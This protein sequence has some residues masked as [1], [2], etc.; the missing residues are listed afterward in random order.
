MGSDRRRL[1]IGLSLAA[2]LVLGAWADRKSGW[3]APAFDAIAHQFYEIPVLAAIRRP[4]QVPL[5]RIHLGTLV[6]IVASGLIA[7]PW[8]PRHAR[9]FWAIIAAGY[10]IR[11]TIWI[12]GGN[13]PLVPGDSC[14]YLEVASSVYRGEG[15]VKHY[16]E[17][18]FIDYPAI[19]QNR[20]VLDDWATP[21]HAYVLAGAYRLTGVVPGQSIESTVAVAKGTNFLL[22]MLTLP[23]IYGFAR[24]RFG[25]GVALGSMALLAVL[26]VHALYAGFE[27]RESLVALTSLLAIW[28]L[29]ECWAARGT[30]AWQ[31][32]IVAGLCGGLA[33]LSRNTAMA[34]LAA[35]GIYGLCTHGRRH[36][37]PMLVWGLVTVAVIAPWA[38]A[39]MNEYGEPFYTY[40][41][42]FPYNFSWTVHHYEKGNTRAS[43]FYTI[44]NAPTIVRVK[45]K[46][47]L[48]IGFYSTMILSVPVVLGFV[49]RLRRPELDTAPGAREVDRL[50][51][52]LGA[53][54]VLG[55]L[56]NVADVT[57]VAQLGRYYLPIFVL[58]LPTAAAGMGD[59]LAARVSPRAWRAL[60][61]T[62][63]ALVWADPTWAYDATWFVKPYQLHWPAIREAGDWIRTHPQAVPANARIMT[64]FPWELRLASQR[65][66]V[67]MP[68]SLFAQHVRRTIGQYGVTHVLWGSFEPAP[69]VDPELYVP[70]LDRLRNGLGLTEDREVYRSRIRSEYPVRLYRLP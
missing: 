36:V 53:A 5:V 24:R 18:F 41:K 55:T 66:T 35:A 65:T 8:L 56:V 6:A 22:N 38:W 21:L 31:W 16:V 23:A 19:R 54:F 42:Y 49:R 52:V 68:R 28:T 43:E 34:L 46:S 10:A 11:A 4:T 62:L 1:T 44:A 63:V 40:T 27:L 47:L 30:R 39:T 14:H 60:A 20:G 7:S 25:F 70:Y 17:S 3:I 45:F 61:V 29:T 69:N 59:W 33:I 2:L 15:P 64:W 37:G 50:V 67:L 48:I 51:V 58:M 13:L 9:T 57:Q 12:A 32:A 26:P